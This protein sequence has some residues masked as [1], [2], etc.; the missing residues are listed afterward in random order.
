MSKSRCPK[1]GGTSFAGPGASDNSGPGVWAEYLF[2]VTC[3]EL[4]V[5]GGDS[6][7]RDDD[8]APGFDATAP[9]AGPS[10]EGRG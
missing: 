2:C 6:Q 3:G 10:A 5:K 7:A 9:A 8:T 4:V 1:C